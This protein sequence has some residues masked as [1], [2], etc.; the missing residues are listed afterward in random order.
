MHRNDQLAVI[1]TDD[2]TQ[3]LARRLAWIRLRDADEWL[4][5]EDVPNLTKSGLRHLV[6]AINGVALRL[7]R[8]AILDDQDADVDGQQVLGWVQ[9]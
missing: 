1:L 9:A 5:W 7:E 2:E 4:E 3:A 8:A 6:D